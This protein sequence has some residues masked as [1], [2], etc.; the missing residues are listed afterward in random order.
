MSELFDNMF[1]CMFENYEHI[2][3]E[4]DVQLIVRDFTLRGRKIALAI[5]DRAQEKVPV[6][7]GFLKSSGYI[8]EDV[9]GFMVRYD[10]EY[11]IYVH[12]DIDVAHPNGG[13]AHF[14][15]DAYKEIMEELRTGALII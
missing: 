11:A 8:V 3:A 12:E 2:I 9:E 4:D 14:L 1:G 13:Q 6:D 7:T 5:L 15:D 10:A